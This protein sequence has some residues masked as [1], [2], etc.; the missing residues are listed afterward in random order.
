MLHLWILRH[1]EAHAHAPSDPER[2]LTPRGE[3]DAR[4]A[5][6]WLAQQPARPRRLLASPY[7]RAQQT[8]AAV[9][10]AMPELRIETVPWLTPD[11]DPLAVVRQLSSLRGELLV[12]SH[13]PLVGGLVAALVDGAVEP[14]VPLPTAGL[15]ELHLPV[16][17]VGC[18]ELRSLR[19]PPAYQQ[20]RRG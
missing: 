18:A 6:L 13:Q 14:G 7:L 2:P 20:A 11:D 4:A 10:V 9:I 19:F 8:A 17:A 16:V 5:G 15:A 3:A 1:G 12:V